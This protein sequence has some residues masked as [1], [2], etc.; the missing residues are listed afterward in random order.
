MNEGLIPNR[1]AKALYKYATE[2]GV[3]KEV[4]AEMQQLSKSYANEPVLAPTVDNP[5]VALSDKEKVL[6]S[7][8]GATQGGCFDKFILLVIKHNRENFMQSASDNAKNLLDDLQLEY[9]KLRQQ[10][11]TTEL[12]DIVGGQVER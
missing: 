9:N 10:G 3:A 7:A 6:L 5:F 8:S 1:Y 4:Y 2:E 12:L 11:I